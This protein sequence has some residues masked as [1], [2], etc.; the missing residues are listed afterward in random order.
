MQAAASANCKITVAGKISDPAFHK[1]VAAVK[2]LQEQNPE[3]VTGECLHF[4]ETQWEEYIKR[5][6]NK[7]KGVFY[8]HSGSHLILI[9]DCEYVGNAEQFA[10]YILHKFAYMDNSMSIVYERLASN[11]YKKMINTSKTRKYAKLQLTHQGMV[12]TVYF[13]LFNDIAPRTCANFLQLCEGFTRSDGER[14]EY[15]G[16]NVH[17]IVKG[18]FIQMGKIT[19][20]KNPELGT[21][22]YGQNFE[23]ESFQM[24]HDEIGMLGMSKKNGLAHTNEAQFYVSMGAPL[25]FLDN[26]NVIFGRVIMG[27]RALKLIEKLECTNEK[28][29]ETIKITQCGP[30]RL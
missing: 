30:Y 28:P 7:L 17:R 3:T 12:S 11:S 22:I 8:Q 10:T 16:Q 27:M 21:S 26:K 2:Y 9:N 24:K 13:E 19:P 4:F 25:T 20:S 1:C 15:G 6:A 23:D 29:N 14:L 5:T 18:M